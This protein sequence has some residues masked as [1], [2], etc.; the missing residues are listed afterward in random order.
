MR[1]TLRLLGLLLLWI[2]GLWPL[3]LLVVYSQGP[4][5]AVELE[6]A[7]ETWLGNAVLAVLVVGLL[8]MLVYPPLPT[9]VRLLAT[10][11]LSRLRTEREPLLRAQS[12]LRNFE[13]PARHLEAGRAALGTGNPEIALPHLARSLELEPD[14]PAALHQLGQALLELGKPAAAI[15]PLARA[16]QLAPDQG[17]GGALLLLGRAQ[18][19]AGNARQA[20][21]LLERHAR[22]HGG[23]R[24]SQFWL[25]TCRREVGDEPAART[26]FTAAA[27][28][29]PERPRLTA[30]EAWYRARA[31]VAL[32]GRGGD[33]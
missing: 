16:V 22:E 21:E 26:A 10:R 5:A 30:E 25:G 18:M 9:G 2:I 32:W 17:F 12:E 15:G 13:S 19:R 4:M 29:P 33:K 24:K 27:A 20:A 1:S 23:S 6:V 14:Q 31:R 3:V 28:P 11:T 8:L 7:A